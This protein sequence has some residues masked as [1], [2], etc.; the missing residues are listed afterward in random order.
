MLAGCALSGE[1]E[2][3]GDDLTAVNNTQVGDAKVRVTPHLDS[4][5]SEC[6]VYRSNPDFEEFWYDYAR[7]LKKWHEAALISLRQNSGDPSE[8]ARVEKLID[9]A[10]QSTHEVEDILP[11]LFRIPPGGA[12]RFGDEVCAY[13]NELFSDQV[14]DNP[15]YASEANRALWI[16]YGIRSVCARKG[17]LPGPAELTHQRDGGKMLLK[18]QDIVIS[19]LCPE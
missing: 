17:K 5:E 11:Y 9:E 14:D 4:G 10:P 15:G 19:T 18:F 3:H 2:P 6:E 13:R 12:A 7:Y 8:T 1:T 16:A